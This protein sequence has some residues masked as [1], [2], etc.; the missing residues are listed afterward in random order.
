M[1]VLSVAL[2]LGRDLKTAID[3][4]RISI[5]NGTSVTVEDAYQGLDQ[6][7]LA[8]LKEKEDVRL[9]KLPYNSV[10]SVDKTVDSV[11]PYND[12]RSGQLEL[13]PE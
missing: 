9:L 10:N 6:Q 13:I 4:P 7:V 12:P 1:Q 2:F 5:V 11:L 3:D 8:K